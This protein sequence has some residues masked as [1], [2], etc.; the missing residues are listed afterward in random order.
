MVEIRTSH[1]HDPDSV[2]F[3]SMIDEH[4][5]GFANPE[6]VLREYY[7]IYTFQ[8]ELAFL[9][10]RSAVKLNLEVKPR[11]EHSRKPR[12]VMAKIDLMSFGIHI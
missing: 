10:V 6:D 11:I 2:R 3:P 7:I 5:F 1:D 9:S 4:T 8:T 12:V